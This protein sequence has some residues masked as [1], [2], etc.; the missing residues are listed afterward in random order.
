[1]YMPNTPI[2]VQNIFIILEIFFFTYTT[3]ILVSNHTE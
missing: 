1:M 3:T 2:R